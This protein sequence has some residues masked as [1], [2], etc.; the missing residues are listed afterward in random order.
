MKKLI[1][2][3]IILLIIPIAILAGIA[4][5]STRPGGVTRDETGEIA[6]RWDSSNIYDVRH[7]EN[8]NL[9]LEDRYAVFTVK[10]ANLDRDRVVEE[11]VVRNIE[12][13]D[14]SVLKY[15]SGDI[16]DYKV[17]GASGKIGFLAF[18]DGKLQVHSGEIENG[19]FKNIKKLS[20]SET[21]VLEW[22][23][24]DDGKQIAYTEKRDEAQPLH[25]EKLGSLESRTLSVVDQSGKEI[26]LTDGDIFIGDFDWAPE[27][28]NIS[29]E[30]YISEADRKNEID[31]SFIESNM[32]IRQIDI[33]TRTPVEITEQS[34]A[35]N[36]VYSKDARYI[37]YTALRDDV[38]YAKDIMLYDRQSGEI[39]SVAGTENAN[40]DLIDF[41]KDGELLF[42][43][44]KGTGTSLYSV[45]LSESGTPEELVKSNSF[46][47]SYRMDSEA[48]RIS[49]TDESSKEAPESWIYDIGD[50]SKT[51]ITEENSRLKDK[52]KIETET[53][54]W[55]SADG[56]EVEGLLSLPVGY[57]EGERY[58]LIL[59][60]NDGLGAQFTDS[61]TDARNQNYPVSLFSEEGFCTLRVNAR[62]SDGYG[63]DFRNGASGNFGELVSEDAISGMEYLKTRGIVDED[64]ISIM[65]WG[66]GAYNASI[67]TSKT[68]LFKTAVL[69]APIFEIDRFLN[70]T[71]S[72]TEARDYFGDDTALLESGSISNRVES[73]N[74]PTLI[75]HGMQDRKVMYSEGV[76]YYNVLVRSG[77]DASMISYREGDHEMQTPKLRKSY[78]DQILDWMENRL[79]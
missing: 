69:G 20:D 31:R 29:Y 33:A 1:D 21:G 63:V 36:P 24:S 70:T 17:S 28:D 18:E 66:Y 9:I 27:G 44:S 39:K 2:K 22:K 55:S 30:Y 4:Y 42:S 40:P 57:V 72:Y 78:I 62:G 56:T 7:L 43:E 54:R 5:M 71:D 41:S 60:L 23:W 59:K 67:A 45:Q 65:G 74:T 12:T 35:S 34:G 6:E 64:N 10:K 11:T 25:G 77:K 58:P 48:G 16:I 3:N 73:L 50:K 46:E 51:Q 15:N 53:V 14:I 61:Y 13:G 76:S 52:H 38:P 47:P 75:V 49:Y 37:A 8:A 79:N 26:E 68:D 32:K 19:N